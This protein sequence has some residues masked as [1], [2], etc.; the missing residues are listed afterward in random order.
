MLKELNTKTFYKMCS[1][2]VLGHLFALSLL[3]GSSYPKKS[4]KKIK[5]NEYVVQKPKVIHKKQVLQKTVSLK[6]NPEKP[7]IQKAAI[8]KPKMPNK[9]TLKS[10]VSKKEIVPKEPR[11]S[12]SKL[13]ALEK[14]LEKISSYTPEKS[15]EKLD[16][17][18]SVSEPI[19]LTSIEP[20]HEEA[21]KRMI[22]QLKEALIIPEK[23]N[24]KISFCVD[25][26]GQISDIR[27]L[28]YESIK[29]WQYIKKEL[30]KQ[31]F[32]WFNQT[33]RETIIINFISN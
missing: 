20:S 8:S 2:V 28:Q 18:H 11:V 22:E 27:L 32:P 4:R 30:P 1:F 19:I 15:F 12:L 24:V 14:S 6:K 3:S 23:G 29:N 31:Y 33:K 9:P 7:L 17:S 5:I 21:A 16:I 25:E 10:K 13:H 26:K